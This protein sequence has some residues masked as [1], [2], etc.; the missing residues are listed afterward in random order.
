MAYA[1][2]FQGLMRKYLSTQM[3]LYLDVCMLNMY[4]YAYILLF[5]EIINSSDYI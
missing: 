2:M 5:V 1:N 3:I 4:K